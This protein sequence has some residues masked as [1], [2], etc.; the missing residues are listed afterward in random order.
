M[1]FDQKIIFSPL[2]ETL[3]T[4]DTIFDFWNNLHKFPISRTQGNHEYDI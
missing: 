4:T 3:I 1:T 2:I